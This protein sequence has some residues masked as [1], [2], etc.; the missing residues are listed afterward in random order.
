MLQARPTTPTVPV[1]SHV[2]EVGR[3]RKHSLSMNDAVGNVK[4][5]RSS[6][7]N[8]VSVDYDYDQ[9]NRLSLFMDSEKTANGPISFTYDRN[10]N[11]NDDAVL[12]RRATD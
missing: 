7:G 4:T 2:E 9:L 11:L 3:R 8:G 10:G 12:E 1:R 6:N 5:L